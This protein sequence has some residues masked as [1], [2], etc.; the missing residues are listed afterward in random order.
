MPQ[1][2][3][4]KAVDDIIEPLHRQPDGCSTEQ[5][6]NLPPQRHPGGVL[7]SP[8]IL[9]SK[10]TPAFFSFS[11]FL[12][13]HAAPIIAAAAMAIRPSFREMLRR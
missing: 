9:F 2:S 4:V 12:I 3:E 6:A 5:T 10:F 1:Y 8:G 11:N 13:L 7:F